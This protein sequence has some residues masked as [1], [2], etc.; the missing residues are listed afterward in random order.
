MKHILELHKSGKVA[1]ICSVC[2]AHP[3]V[4]EAALRF[5]LET[6]RTVLIEATS[7]QVNQFGGYTGMKPTDFRDFVLSIA[8]KVG[9]PKE[10]ICLG[11]DHLGPNC[12]RDKSP[13]VAM[14]LSRKLVADY[15]AAG[16]RKIHLDASMAVA[17]EVDP[18]DP[19]VVAERAADLC[20]AC[21][22]AATDGDK[23]LYIIGTEVPVPGGETDGLDGIQ[24]SKVPDVKETIELHRTAFAKRGLEDA[25][26]RVIGVVVQPGVDFD[27]TSII[28]YEPE[29]AAELAKFIESQAGM[30][31]EAHS[32]DYQPK[33]KFFELVRDHFAILKVGPAL[34]FALREG[35]FAL[36]AIEDELIPAE[37]RSQLRAVMERI[38]TDDPS[39]WQRYYQG[40]A[41]EQKILR[42]YSNSDRIR[43][44]WPQTEVQLA[45]EKLMNNL[46]DQVIIDSLAR[47]YVGFERSRLAS[48]GKPVTAT[49]VLLDKV[50]QVLED[51]RFGC[52]DA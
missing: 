13:A 25:F 29:K 12:W 26:S 34:T 8:E 11:G 45:V 10:R 27:H 38:M 18:I 4:I 19:A 24:I 43:Y 36:A 42:A 33:E 37:Q 2:S 49:S 1:G 44:Y 47:Q 17:S 41:S 30:V 7:N 48:A 5:D 50:T 22:E 35:Y 31:F 9:F 3:L 14:E 52:R 15:V 16:F 6:N 20:Q 51:Y 23:P 21:E 40:N 39:Q 28:A 46:G 32:T